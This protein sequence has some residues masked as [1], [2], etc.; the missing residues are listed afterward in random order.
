MP[1]KEEGVCM[2]WVLGKRGRFV[3]VFKDA[4]SFI[5]MEENVDFVNKIE[6]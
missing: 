5:V 6:K 1:T 4:V 3:F 2:G